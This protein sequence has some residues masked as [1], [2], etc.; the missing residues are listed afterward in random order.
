MGPSTVNNVTTPGRKQNLFQSAAGFGGLEKRSF[1]GQI[2]FLDNMRKRKQSEGAALL[3]RNSITGSHR[4]SNKQV[5]DELD[6]EEFEESPAVAM[7]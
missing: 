3:D 6:Q 1:G 7:L 2:G 5:E 4:S